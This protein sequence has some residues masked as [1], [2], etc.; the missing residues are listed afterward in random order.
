[1]AERERAADHRLLVGLFGASLLVQGTA[2][3]AG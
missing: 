2:A 1:V 3:L